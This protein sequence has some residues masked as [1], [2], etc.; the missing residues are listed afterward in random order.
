M[1]VSRSFLRP[2]VHDPEDEV[3]G[4]LTVMERSFDE[5]MGAV[6]VT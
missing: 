3:A 4:L 2:F 1:D 6:A 5:W